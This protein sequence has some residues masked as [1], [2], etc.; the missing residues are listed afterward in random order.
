M[1]KY[2]RFIV[3]L[4][5]DTHAGHKLGLLNPETE[6]SEYDHEGKEYKRKIELGST[7]AFLWELY[8]KHLKELE[9]LAGK[10]D[11]Y[12]FHL[13]DLTQGKKYRDNL[14]WSDDYGQYTAAFYNML[15]ML[16]IK[17]V[18][19][20]RMVWGTPSH[21]FQE[22]TAP[23]M[24]YDRLRTKFSSKNIR[25]V[26]HGLMDARGV[27]IDYAHHG[28]FPGSRNWL[29][30]NVARYDIKSMMQ[31]EIDLGHTPPHLMVRG[32]FHQRLEELV[33]KFANG[34]KYE[35]RG[36]LIPS[37]TMLDDYAR[38]VAK[39]PSRVTNGMAAVEV[40]DGRI[41]YVHWLTKTSDVRVK[42]SVK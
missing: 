12:S 20:F 9:K 25:A 6:I 28:F 38:Q 19:V 3:A 18:K 8:T 22:N 27:V 40:I 29:K 17:N 30:G 7:Q 11:I 35:T 33:I 31:D 42:E 13:G 16:R 37:Y 26:P 14:V 24:V 2:D 32:H 15:P 36:L 1:K 39:S 21:I 5:S 4:F 10:N 34:F 41:H 23:K